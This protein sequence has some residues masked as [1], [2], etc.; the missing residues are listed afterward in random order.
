MIKKTILILLPILVLAG[1]FYYKTTQNMTAEDIKNTDKVPLE[2]QDNKIQCPVCKMY[3]VGKTFSAQVITKDH[4]THFFDDPGCVALWLESN[5]IDKK[6]VTIWIYTIDTKRYI[7]ATKA[8]YSI[9]DYA[10]PMHYGFGAYEHNKK[11]FIDF[12]EMVLR[13]L[14]GENMTNPKIRK[15]IL[16]DL[17]KDQQ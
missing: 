10:D 4:K 13:M 5:K 1:L 3:L 14:R 12:D 7:D 11:G 6:D 9:Y 17:K 16:Q 2:F 15:K 8:H